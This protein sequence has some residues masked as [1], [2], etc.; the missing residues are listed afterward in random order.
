M[1]NVYS[2]G[3]NRCTDAGELQIRRDSSGQKVEP[4]RRR[5][6]RESR[7]NGTTLRP[8]PQYLYEVARP[9]DI[10]S[11][12]EAPGA[13]HS[14]LSVSAFPRIR[15]THQN[16]ESTSESRSIHQFSVESGTGKWRLPD[17][18]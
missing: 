10:Q 15:S 6:G 7:K 17:P 12:C 14:V 11:R 2:S 9:R 4:R 3:K 13:R 1:K 8:G 16:P 5:S 18:V